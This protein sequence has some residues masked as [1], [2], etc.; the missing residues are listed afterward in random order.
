MP[1][2]IRFTLLCSPEERELIALLAQHLRRSQADAVR[3]ILREAAAE[4]TRPAPRETTGPEPTA[5][6]GTHA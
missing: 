3:L 4:V 6:E 2:N 5:Q 1:R